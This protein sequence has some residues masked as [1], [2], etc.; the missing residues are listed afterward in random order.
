MKT[1]NTTPANNSH[2]SSIN[3]YN[4]LLQA[5]LIKKEVFDARIGKIQQTPTASNAHHN[6]T[7]QKSHQPQQSTKATIVQSVAPTKPPSSCSNNTKKSA[8]NTVTGKIPAGPKTY[9][10]TG[11][12]GGSLR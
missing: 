8:E 5:G 4:R 10:S 9:P 7:K 12:P 1:K 3:S 11:T 2:S 6:N